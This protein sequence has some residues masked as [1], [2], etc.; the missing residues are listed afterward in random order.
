MF[1]ALIFEIRVDGLDSLSS[2]GEDLV[3]CV[4]S[5]VQG[6]SI[7]R[8]C[9]DWEGHGALLTY[10]RF[11]SG[12]GRYK[13]GREQRVHTTRLVLAVH[14]WARATS[15]TVATDRSRWLWSRF[16]TQAELLTFNL[17][18]PELIKV[19]ERCN[20]FPKSLRCID[21]VRKHIWTVGRPFHHDRSAVAVFYAKLVVA[22]VKDGVIPQEPNRYLKLLGFRIGALM[23]FVWINSPS[24]T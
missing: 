14:C 22:V 5:V 20:Y 9:L 15:S 1:L 17:K 21:E 11:G 2:C 6:L 7:L 23:T 8:N 4:R 16:C 10:L 18:C 19:D 12:L 3:P 13:H 24:R